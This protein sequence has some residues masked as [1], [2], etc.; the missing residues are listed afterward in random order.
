MRL[1]ALARGHTRTGRQFTRYA[2]N[3]FRF[4]IRKRDD[5]CTTQNNGVFVTAMTTSFASTKDQNPI[6]SNV[7]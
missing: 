7:N 2:I 4:Y 1:I 3:G 6:T 5:R